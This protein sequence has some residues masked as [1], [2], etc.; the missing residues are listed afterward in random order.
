MSADDVSSI[1][2]LGLIEDVSLRQPELVFHVRSTLTQSQLKSRLDHRE[3]SS[4]YAVE[5]EA[6]GMHHEQFTPVA[7]GS[8]RLFNDMRQSRVV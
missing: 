3:H 4:L 2:C 7:R 6:S 1:W 5:M 8:L